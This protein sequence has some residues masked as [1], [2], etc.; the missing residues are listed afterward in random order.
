[1]TSFISIGKRSLSWVMENLKHFSLQDPSDDA[2]VAKLLKPI[3]ELTLTADLINRYSQHLEDSEF[4]KASYEMLDHCWQELKG[5]EILTNF[6]RRYPYLFI[7]ST[8]YPPFKRYGYQC[9]EL[10]IAI[11]EILQVRG[12]VEL[13]FAAWRALDLAVAIKE[14]NFT[15]PWNLEELFT[16]TWL[17]RLPEPWSIGEETAYAVTHSAFYMTQFGQNP[18]GLSDEHRDYLAMWVPAWQRYFARRKN[19]DLLGEMTMVLRCCFNEIDDGVNVAENFSLFQDSDG[20]IIGP[21]DAGLEML[22]P[23]EIDPYRTKFLQNYH[24]T[25]VSLMACVMSMHHSKR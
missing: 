1:M 2:R 12:F 16:R 24:T 13:E 18:Y 9:T 11:Q 23:G 15:C 10:E 25:L 22:D 19:M 20:A 17:Y 5:G 4:K 6:L 14:L 8:I 21:S 7:Y 3:G